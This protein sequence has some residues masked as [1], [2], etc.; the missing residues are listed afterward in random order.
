MIEK[1]PALIR[2][3]NLRLRT[4][5]GFKPEEQEKMQDVVI[6]VEIRYDAL[7]AATSDDVELALDYKRLTKEIIAHVEGNRFLL[8]EKLV[9]DLL[10][11]AMAYP[12]AQEVAVEVD[13]PHALRFADSVALR[14]TAR[15]E[16]TGR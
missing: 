4:Y 10:Q 8:L 15:R 13:K 12:L 1:E 6:N 14:M 16:H 7:A 3:K 2:I 9:H 11:M 5:I